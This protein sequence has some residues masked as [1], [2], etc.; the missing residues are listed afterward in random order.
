M[1]TKLLFPLLIASILPLAG[2]SETE[3]SW[4]EKDNL[5][6]EKEIP[7]KDAKA[8]L[9]SSLLN[10]QH[11]KGVD[12]SYSLNTFYKN[13]LSNYTTEEDSNKTI[14]QSTTARFYDNNVLV[15]NSVTTKDQSYLHA[16]TASVIKLDSYKFATESKDIREIISED[17]GY[18]DAEVEELPIHRYTN[19]E[20]FLAQYNIGSKADSSVITGK[21]ATYGF[22][23]NNEI[24]VEIMET[25]KSSYTIKFNNSTFPQVKN[26]YTVYRLKAIESQEKE[27]Q[28]IVDYYYRASQILI[29]FDI[30]GEPL[31]SP[32]VLEKEELVRSYSTESNGEYDLSNIPSPTK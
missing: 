17:Y 1:K 28:Y 30:F 32:Y 3:W 9:D 11:I 7:E 22:A 25:E 14:S 20:D 16:S 23:K 13:Y 12:E 19:D 27:A 18:I 10:S 31:K 26:I 4:W 24:I 15:T 21:S 29:G 6:I 5:S 8:A 2:C